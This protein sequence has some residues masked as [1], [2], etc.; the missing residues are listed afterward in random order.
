MSVLL[1]VA[2]ALVGMALL[3]VIALGLAAKRADSGDRDTGWLTAVASLR[4]PSGRPFFA[5]RGAMSRFVED[6]DDVRGYMDE[7]RAR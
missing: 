5:S 6:V 4:S 7:G 2:A 3:L 1:I